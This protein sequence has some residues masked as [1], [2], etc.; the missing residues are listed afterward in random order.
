M[1]SSTT[2]ATAGAG[3]AARACARFA[4]ITRA[5]CGSARSTAAS[6]ASIRRHGRVTSL[7]PRRERPALAQQRSRARD[8]GRRRAPTVGRDLATASTCSIAPPQSFVRYGR[9]ADNPHSL[10]DDDVMSLYQDR[11]G[12]LW[13]GTRAGGASHW[14]PNSWALGHYRSALFAQHG[15]E[16]IRR[17]WRGHGVGRNLRRP[18][19]DRHAR[20]GANVATRASREGPLRLADDRVMSLLLRS[21]R[22]AVDRHDER[23]AR[24]ASIRQRGSVRSYQ[25]RR[26]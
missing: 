1:I 26:R 24:R 8:L 10:R 19:R 18:R 22:R 7:S 6:I 16:C 20:R 14:S 3:S 23:R 15:R 17:R 4:R 13:V 9:D 25:T 5:R 21:R 11:G 12:V 2:V